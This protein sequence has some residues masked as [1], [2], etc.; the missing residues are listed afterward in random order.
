M[1]P[2]SRPLAIL[3]LTCVAAVV[4]TTQAKAQPAS[5]IQLEQL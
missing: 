3:I 4:C 1:T 2:I 5:V